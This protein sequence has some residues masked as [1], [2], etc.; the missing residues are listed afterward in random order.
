MSEFDSKHFYFKFNDLVI[1]SN[2]NSTIIISININLIGKYNEIMENYKFPHYF[3]E[4]EGYSYLI[5]INI[6]PCPI[7][8]FSFPFNFNLM[9][10]KAM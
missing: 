5:K 10:T 9:Y 1:N 8:K 2:E 7:G 4:K 6:P 3:N